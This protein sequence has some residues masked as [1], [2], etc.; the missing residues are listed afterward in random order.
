MHTFSLICIVYIPTV[1][2]FAIEDRYCHAS[3][4]FVSLSLCHLAS[5]LA[6][7][8]FVS[9]GNSHAV[10]SVDISS[11]S[12]RVSHLSSFPRDHV[13]FESEK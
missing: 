7:S 9:A 10:R 6:S 11:F 2:F 1:F 8:L 13:I 4:S 12:G 3:D 5:Q